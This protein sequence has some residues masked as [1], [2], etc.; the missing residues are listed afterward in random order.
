[1]VIADETSAGCGDNE[2]AA[3]YQVSFDT[4][5]EMCRMSALARQRSIGSCAVQ[6]DMKYSDIIFRAFGNLKET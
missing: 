2:T 1:L 3:A 6:L 4:V 5:D